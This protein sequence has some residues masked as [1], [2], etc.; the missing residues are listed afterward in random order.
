LEIREFAFFIKIPV[1]RLII[2]YPTVK[3]R[4]KNFEPTSGTG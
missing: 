4:G 2:I 3:L 1:E